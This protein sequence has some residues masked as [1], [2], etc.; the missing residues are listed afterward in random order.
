MSEFKAYQFLELLKQLPFVESI[1]LY[2][3]R[4]RGDNR[5]R[6]DIDLAIGA[7]QASWRDWLKVEDIIENADTLLEIDCIHLEQVKDQQFLKNIMKDKLTLFKRSPNDGRN[8]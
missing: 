8:N 5:P 1:Y 3:S 4:A 6:S 7:P 2:G